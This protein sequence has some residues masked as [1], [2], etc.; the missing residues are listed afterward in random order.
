M[1]T[2]RVLNLGVQEEYKSLDYR[3]PHKVW[4]ILTKDAQDALRPIYTINIGLVREDAIN[5]GKPRGGGY[6]RTIQEE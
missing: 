3:V 6:V 5:T 1:K 2:M 4:E